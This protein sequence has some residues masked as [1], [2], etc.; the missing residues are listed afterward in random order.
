MRFVGHV[1][2]MDDTR[3]T[4]R[5]W[6]ATCLTGNN[7]VKEVRE[8]WK[9]IGIKEKIPQTTVEDRPSYRSLVEGHKWNDTRIKF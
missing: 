2:R 5:I 9:T 1:M 4:K 6:N 7:W 8:D 3:L